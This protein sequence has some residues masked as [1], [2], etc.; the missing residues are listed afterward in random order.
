LARRSVAGIQNWNRRISEEGLRI[1]TLPI[2]RYRPRWFLTR[3]P[4]LN[5]GEAI[6]GETSY[7]RRAPIMN[8][9]SAQ[10]VALETVIENRP[11]SVL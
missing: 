4:E 7:G 6:F 9:S 11:D 8:L 5:T 3:S 10:R 1:S 2:M